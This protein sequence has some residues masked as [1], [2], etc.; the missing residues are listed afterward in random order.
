M[1]S[2][3][4]S[5]VAGFI[6]RPSQPSPLSDNLKR[7]SN[8]QLWNLDALSGTKVAQFDHFLELST[9]KLSRFCSG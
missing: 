3:T 2:V 6:L 7:F 1:M 8:L 9:L 4:I 5:T